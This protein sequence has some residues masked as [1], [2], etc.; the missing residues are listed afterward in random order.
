MNNKNRGKRLSYLGIF[1]ILCTAITTI[2]VKAPENET[3]SKKESSEQHKE[4][5]VI[6]EMQ[7]EDDYE[8]EENVNIEVQDTISSDAPEEN[9]KLPLSYAKPVSGT[10]ISDFSMDVPVYSKT[11]GDY[12]THRGVDFSVTKKESVY[13]SE[14]GEIVYAE[15]D[16]LMGETIKIKHTNGDITVY[17]GLLSTSDMVEG[18]QVTKGQVIGLTGGSIPVEDAEEMHLHFEI[19]VEGLYKNPIELLTD[20]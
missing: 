6:Y 20:N 10:V 15:K 11:M 7:V 4:N 2:A 3:I 17:S 9:I 5:E 8:I 16:D 12:R 1:L 14:S 13:A 19:I 18:Q